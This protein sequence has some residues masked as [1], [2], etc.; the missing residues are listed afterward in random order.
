MLFAMACFVL[1]YL[2][3]VWSGGD[4]TWEIGDG[5]WDVVHAIQTSLSAPG[6]SRR[7]LLANGMGILWWRVLFVRGARPR[8]ATIA[9]LRTPPRRA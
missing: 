7:W 1:L 2:I 9:T 4:A 5:G 3:S 8:G 6:E